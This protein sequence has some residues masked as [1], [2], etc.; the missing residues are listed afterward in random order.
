M[1]KQ[2][3]MID[4]T[5]GGVRLLPPAFLIYCLTGVSMVAAQAPTFD[6]NSYN[7]TGT[8]T[9][10][11][12]IL[13]G[14]L[15]CAFILTGFLSMYI[16][17]CGGYSL[18]YG[19]GGLL[20]VVILDGRVQPKGIDSSVINRFPMFI[21]SAV[22]QL[23]SGKGP[24]EC[25]VCLNEFEDEEILK[26]LP[27]CNHVF[28]PECIDAWLANHTTCPVCRANLVP[29]TEES[30]AGNHDQGSSDCESG[31]ETEIGDDES[32][33]VRIVISEE[34]NKT[35][36]N[37]GSEGEKSEEPE[38]QPGFS[39][40]NSTG[41][42]LIRFRVDNSERFTLILPEE[43]RKQ[44]MTMAKLKRT[45]S[46]PRLSSSRRGF[47][48]GSFGRSSWLFGRSE[49]WQTASFKWIT[50]TGNRDLTPLELSR[51]LDVGI[52]A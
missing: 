41:Q 24:L 51:S 49:R 31:T 25:A 38:K 15:F 16:R 28:H 39:R 42:S 37:R 47:R 43:W 35:E 46:M 2:N 50:E 20:P 11:M 19:T 30:E 14:I 13:V 33:V 48:E 23:K 26:L 52:P 32:H 44:V 10:S 29:Q 4:I 22:K 45:A 36:Q 5:R 9:P 8:M 34:E 1:E 40:S 21:Y 7:P 17:W 3:Q 12:G 18:S 27:K 6:P